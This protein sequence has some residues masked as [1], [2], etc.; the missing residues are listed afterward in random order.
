MFATFQSF[1]SSM[2]SKFYQT[3][4][5]LPVF[6]LSL[7]WNNMSLPMFSPMSYLPSYRTLTK[8]Y[9]REDF[10]VLSKRGPLHLPIL[11]LPA[12][13]H[14]MFIRSALDIWLSI[15]H[16]TQAILKFVDS[17]LFGEATYTC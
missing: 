14:N 5:C 17:N 11:H 6:V 1:L 10:F 7:P 13:S 3:L 12:Y 9:F 15:F 16:H 2:S 4:S 8:V